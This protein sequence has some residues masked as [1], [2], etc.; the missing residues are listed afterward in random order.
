MAFPPGE[1]SRQSAPCLDRCTVCSLASYRSWSSSRRA[2]KPTF[3]HLLHE[4]SSK[5]N[6]IDHTLRSITC[7]SSFKSMQLSPV[8]DASAVTHAIFDMSR[9]RQPT[10]SRHR[11]DEWH[12][13]RVHSSVPTHASTNVFFE[14]LSSM[15]VACPV[16]RRL[17]VPT[18]RLSTTNF[19]RTTFV[20]T[21]LLSRLR[22]LGS[23]MLGLEA[24]AARADRCGRHAVASTGRHHPSIDRP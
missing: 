6:Y 23:Q 3:R 14:L 15:I 16:T 1:R 24:R 5:F 13:H 7:S 20:A 2:M 8:P 9:P 22:S 12:E 11:K 4:C 10:F 21:G 17:T 18:P 19:T